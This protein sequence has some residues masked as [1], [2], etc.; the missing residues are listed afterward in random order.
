MLWSQVIICVLIDW[1]PQEDR[2]S[3]IW[4]GLRGSRAREETVE[5]EVWKVDLHPWSILVVAQC[6]VGET[7]FIKHFKSGIVYIHV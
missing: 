5:E 6:M 7:H 1:Q 3:V 4:V 2:S